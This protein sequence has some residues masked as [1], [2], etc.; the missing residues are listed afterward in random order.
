MVVDD[1]S[2]DGTWEWLCSLERDGTP[3]RVRGLR[4]PQ[5][6]QGAAR[7]RALAEIES[8]LVIF[9]G[10]DVIPA[11]DFV[12]THCAAHQRQARACAVVGFTDWR[13]SA[14][15]VTPAL[16][17]VNRE[18][19]QFGYAHMR[20][21]EEVPFTCF[22]TSN[23][24]VPRDVL[25]SEPFAAAF[26]AY[27]WED[28]E[29]GYRLSRRGVPIVYEPLAAA[30]H[31]HPMTLVDLFERQRAAGRGMDTLLQLHPEL[32]GSPHLAA[33]HAPAWFPIARF[34]VPPVLP[35]FDLLDRS[36]L[37][38]PKG[39]LHRVLLCGFYLGRRQSR[40][41]APSG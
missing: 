6:G 35:L 38:L 12:A 8:G 27:G 2:R 9:I 4:Q 1:G 14:M 41:E 30:E 15:R 24:S 16:E 10:D 33:A 17:M 36:G 18:G 7:N 22:Y 25:G 11:P 13:R 28:V 26:T 5:S 3:P 34:L 37:R 21:G 32:E 20:P 31:Q 19:H 29:L 39:L 23:V 40:G